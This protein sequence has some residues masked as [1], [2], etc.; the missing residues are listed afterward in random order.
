[1]K[2]STA[3]IL[4]C[5]SVLLI[6]AGVI[7]GMREGYTDSGM[8]GAVRDTG[9]TAVRADL[10]DVDVS[11]YS[12][13]AETLEAEVYNSRRV[14]L[15]STDGVLRITQRPAD[16]WDRFRFFDRNRGS[17]VVWIP[18]RKID[19]I[20]VRTGSG[21]VTVN[22]LSEE[23]GTAMEITTGSG[24]ISVY[25]SRLKRAALNSGSGSVWTGS[26]YLAEELSI[27][28]GSGD[29]SLSDTG[30]ARIALQTGSGNLWGGCLES[31]GDLRVETGSGDVSLSETDAAAITLQ[32][33]SGDVWVD[34]TTC[35]E[36]FSLTTGSGNANL[37]ELA[38]PDTR[39]RTSSGDVWCTLPGSR[40]DYVVSIA[41]S[42]GS[43]SAAPAADGEKTVVIS[44]SSGDVSV[45]YTD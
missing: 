11:F 3:V 12:S 9:F 32:T 19:S 23:D 31:E 14:E 38:S 27:V 6:T 17:V 37:T 1:M 16:F 36:S 20:S 44:T 13:C 25:N 42:S 41:T 34:E 40:E 39:I 22:S 29:V 8:A 26:L 4:L 18:E 28:T 2:K 33:S 43:V 15:D 21:C 7:L 30:A 45:D 10:D 35:G 5:V 24:E